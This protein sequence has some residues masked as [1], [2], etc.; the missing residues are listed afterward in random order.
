MRSR[1]IALGA[2]VVIAGCSRLTE[3]PETPPKERQARIAPGDLSADQLEKLEDDAPGQ[4]PAEEDED[5]APEA[6]ADEPGPKAEE[7][8]PSPD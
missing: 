3:R 4:H 6:P 8:E 1:S 5:Q 2:L 7:K